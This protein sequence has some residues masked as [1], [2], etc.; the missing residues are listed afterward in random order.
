MKNLFK[1]I[2]KRIKLIQLKKKNIFLHPT[3]NSKKEEKYLNPYISIAAHSNIRNSLIK[4]YTYIGS[5][6][7]LR[8]FKI[9]KFCSIGSNVKGV[10]G[11]HPTDLIS[12]HPIFYKKNNETAV[13]R[14]LFKKAKKVNLKKGVN[15]EFKVIIGNDVW[16]GNDVRIM[17]GV[18]IHDGS[19][20]GT[21]SIVTKDVPPYAIVV[22]VPAK[23]KKYRFNEN[24][25]RLLLEV[26]WWNKDFS[27]I[28]KNKELFLKPDE[29]FKEIIK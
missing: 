14:S 16:I 22:G 2:R 21:G 8:S 1:L 27:W 3:V 25:I 26:K 20:I 4:S 23:V 29:F 10:F 18:T 9:G 5:N 7:S 11:D 28:E 12:T 15:D 6:C 19:I 17:T 13:G 24:N